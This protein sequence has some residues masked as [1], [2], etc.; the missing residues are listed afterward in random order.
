MKIKIFLAFGLI[1]LLTGKPAL[2]TDPHLFLTPN[3]GN[4]SQSF[5]VEIKVDTGGQAAGG[6]DVHLEFP[7]NLLKIE[8][9]TKGE[10]FTEVFSS[11]KNDE[12]K[13]RI[14][15]YFPYSEAG[16]S[17][18][19]SNGLV[20]TINFSPLGTGRATVNFSCTP[21]S[22][23][24]SNI[25]EKIDVKDIIV[26]SANV[27]G[28][29]NVS[30]GSRGTTPTPTPTR[31]AGTTPTPTPTTTS[32]GT[33]PTPTPTVPVSGSTAQTVGLIGLGILTLLTGLVLVF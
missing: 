19:G 33:T 25:V 11:I 1:F 30:G 2:A 17:F 28:D 5:N 20:A 4:Y 18:N 12:G 7:K 10:A 3:S 14:N 31:S 21:E 32:A 24:E 8:R 29:Y 15:A 23:I 26:C 13:L 27:N 9:V 16:R 22:T 6:V